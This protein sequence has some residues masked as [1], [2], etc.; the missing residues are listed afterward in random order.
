MRIGPR[1][2]EKDSNGCSLLRKKSARLISNLFVFLFILWCWDWNLGPH[3]LGKHSTTE[4]HLQAQ[5]A[6]LFLS[7][8][9]PEPHPQAMEYHS[10]QSAFLSAGR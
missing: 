3:T 1:S 4:L 9:C 10:R 8:L 6:C 2:W 7:G 5:Y